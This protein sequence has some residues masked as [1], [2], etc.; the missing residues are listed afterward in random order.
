M[1]MQKV[2][3][4]S[5]LG[6]GA[7]AAGLAVAGCATGRTLIVPA[8]GGDLPYVSRLQV[9][10]PGAIRML[11]VTDIHLFAG[12]APFWEAAN[13][14]SLSDMQAL[15]AE[16]KPDLVIVT[17]DLWRDY[18]AE[19]LDEFA[20]KAI[21]LCGALGVPWAYVWGN[22]D[23]VVNRP[24][25]ED[26]LAK[27]PNSLYR[28][29]GSDG[30]YVL[31]LEDRHGK[32]VWQFLCVNSSNTG[33]VAP[34]QA[35]L[36]SLPDDIGGGQKGLTPRMAAFHI[37]LKQYDT[38]WADGTARGIKCERICFEQEDGTSL[39]VLKSVGVKACFCGHDHV[40]DYSGVVDGVDLI[41]GRATGRGGY[42]GL[43]VRKGGKLYTL[44]GRTG[45]YVWESVLLDNTRWVPGPNEHVDKTP[46]DDK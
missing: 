2:T 6:A 28:G 30:N 26:M 7:A 18:P 45:K 23:Q 31:N 1:S 25:V 27:A 37:P 13:K 4:R 9:R 35:W 39:A 32:V 42:G 38:M 11:Q 16:T 20:Q 10:K 22:H 46:A 21:G 24:A 43:Q 19:K 15:V 33:L 5:F 8:K 40:C 41:Y 44:D 12:E 3:R 17:G 34:Q 14:K 29:A 36:K